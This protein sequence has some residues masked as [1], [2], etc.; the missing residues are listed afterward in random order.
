[1]ILGRA[2]IA[3]MA[4]W[5]ACAHAAGQEED[6]PRFAPA[7]DVAF[8]AD[9]EGFHASRAR[10][11]ALYRY[12]NPWS[13]AG[14]MAQSAHY[15]Q[16]DY[17]KDAQG[18][19]GVYRDQRRDTLSGVD[20][21]AG[22]VRA[23]GHLRPLGDMT[24]RLSTSLSTS[25]DLIGSADLVETPKAL[26][27]GIGQSFAAASVEQRLGERFTAIALAG[28][29]WFS[30]GNAR[31]HLRARLIWLAAPS[32]GA[33]LQLRYREYRSEKADVGGA[34]FNPG[35]YRQWLFAAAIR[36]R[37]AAWIYS[38]A[39]GAGQEKS[40]GADARPS[41]LAEA[42]AEGPLARELRLV[43]RAGY[44]RA[45]GFIDSSAYSYRLI[46]AQVVLPLR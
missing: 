33:T 35:N 38:G 20:I 32:E 4:P 1:V 46:A 34:Y 6:A 42:R 31:D 43:L 23:S 17:R 12:D 22:V 25:V 41:Y 30:D 19:L 21:E 13:F 9:N 7:A 15:S 5:L 28:R 26:D 40:A 3:M 11:G 27:R 37:H 10:A 36:K 39:L 44:Y 16:G 14:A 29:Q 24:L 8:A 45:A 18:I 2:A